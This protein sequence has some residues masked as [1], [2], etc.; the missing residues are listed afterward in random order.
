MIKLGYDYVKVMQRRGRNTNLK[1]LREEMFYLGDF[2]PIKAEYN[3][4]PVPNKMLDDFEYSI[5]T[6]I[7]INNDSSYTV[8]LTD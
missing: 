3:G 2:T 4:I 1:E 7:E 6:F 8:W 5:I